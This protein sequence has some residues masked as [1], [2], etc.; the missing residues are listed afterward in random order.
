MEGIDGLIAS[1]PGWER[2]GDAIGK[3]F[4]FEDFNE[5]MGFVNGVARL[6]E[7]ADHHPDIGISYNKVKIELTTHDAGGLT[8]KDFLLAKGIDRLV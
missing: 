6:A 4:I 7:A 2:K 3:E 8:E 5:A 1:V